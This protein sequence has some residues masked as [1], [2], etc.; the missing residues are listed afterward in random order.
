MSRFA[1][2]PNRGATDTWLTPPTIVKALGPFDL[3]PCAAGNEY[4]WRPWETAAVSWTNGGLGRSWFGMVWCNPPYGPAA[5]EWLGAAAEHGRAVALTLARVETDWFFRTAWDRAAGFLFLRGRINFHDA[6]GRRSDMNC[7]APPVL[8][9]YG[10]DAMRRLVRSGID[11]KVMVNAVA[12]LIRPDGSPVGTWQEALESA[13]SGRQLH[14]R[15]IYAAAEGTSKVRE[16][17]ASGHNWRAQ[18]R[19]SLQRH[20]QPIGQGVWR[21]A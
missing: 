17:K 5:G 21:P 9:A 10:D 12:F 14:I 6:A 20:F 4:A 15:D 7:G 2:A 3:D 11:G 8:I 19:R 18:L 16:A 1:H 13:A